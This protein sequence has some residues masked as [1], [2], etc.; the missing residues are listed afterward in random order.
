MSSTNCSPPFPT[1]ISIPDESAVYQ[2]LGYGVRTVSFLNFHVYA[3][4][5]YINK[6]DILRT[7]NILSSYQNLEE[8]LVDFSKDGD[9]ISNLLK[10]GIRFSI[11]IVP[12][13][14]T[15]FSH[16]RDGFVKTILAHPLSKVLGH[17]EEF[18]NGLQ[19]LKNA[20]SG[21][22]GSVPK[23]QIL[24]MDRSNNGVLRFTYYDSKDESKCTKPEELGQVTEPQ[25]SEI[26]FLQY[27]SGKNPSSESAKNSFLEG[28]VALAK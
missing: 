26:L 23:H 13:R 21:R 25:V 5:I 18:G 22:K 16:L 7:K 10:A 27:L 12:V 2:L 14:N 1:E 4:G 8:D 28:L 3:L 24:I 11:R 6:D 15:D 19:E 17:S 9:I 20:F